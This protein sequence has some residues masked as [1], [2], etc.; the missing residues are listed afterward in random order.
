MRETT[1]VSQLAERDVLEAS[2][3]Y[4]SQVPILGEKF[5]NDFY[6]TLIKLEVAPEKYPFY[7]KNFRRVILHKFPYKI[8]YRIESR[9]I[10]VFRVLHA[11]RDHRRFLT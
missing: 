9:G 3:W 6:Q 8:F 4:E 11:K 1:V 7:Y 10:V 2:L 5:F